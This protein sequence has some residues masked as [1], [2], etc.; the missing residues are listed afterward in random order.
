MRIKNLSFKNRIALYYISTTALLIGFVFVVIYL[1]VDLRV[2]NHL[3]HD[4]QREVDKHVHEI[5]VKDGIIALKKPQEWMEREHNTVGVDPVFIEFLDLKGNH[6]DKSPNLKD[7]DLCYSSDRE[8]YVFYDELLADKRIRQIQVPIV[9]DNGKRVGHLLVA[10]AREGSEIVLETLRQILFTAYPIILIILFLVARFIAGRSIRPINEI[11][12]TSNKITRDNLVERILLPHHKDELHIL[13]AT[14]NQ[15]LD[16]VENVIE[17]EKSFSSYASHEFRTPLAILKGT[18]EV[19]VRKPRQQT[20]YEEKIKYCINEI[21]HLNYLVDQLLILTRFENQKQSLK[22]D[23]QTIEIF[24][25]HTLDYYQ[26]QL[27]QKGITIRRDPSSEKVNLKTDTY[28]FSTIINNLLSNAIKYSQAESTIY[29]NV[30]QEKQQIILEIKDEGI[31]IPEAE[32]QKV[33]DKFYRSSNRSD[34]KG[35]GLGLPIVKQFCS[36]LNIQIQIS[37]KVNNGTSIKLVIPQS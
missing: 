12:D 29:I 28:L 34:I 37:S 5:G 13:S 26:K 20:E 22:I 33:F 18:L 24:I 32:T 11:I 10:V 21:D 17:R 2:S 19:L 14:I 35:F 1:L 7:A 8:D 31:G 6:I 25:N 3:N 16:R 23:G 30:F 4:I 15:L 9:D 36:L 27:E